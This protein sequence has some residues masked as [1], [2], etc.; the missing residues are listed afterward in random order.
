MIRSRG[1]DGARARRRDLLRIGFLSATA[2]AATEIAAT[3]APFM[4]VNRIV[5]LG[6][7]ST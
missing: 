5:G 4:R 2:L 1:I 6:A 7:R 3:F